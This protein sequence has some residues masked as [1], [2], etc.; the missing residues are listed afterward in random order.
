[1]TYYSK[2]IFTY[3]CTYTFINKNEFVGYSI[4]KIQYKIEK[5][6]TLALESNC[7]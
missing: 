6:S 1:M 4:E 2:S 7:S 5:Y 3:P